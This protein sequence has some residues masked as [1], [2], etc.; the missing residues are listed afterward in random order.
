MKRL[1][2]NCHSNQDTLR[3]C[4]S[5]ESCVEDRGD[6]LQVLRPNWRGRRTDMGAVSARQFK[7]SLAAQNLGRIIERGANG[8]ASSGQDR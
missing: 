1:G 7:H 2:L 5:D 6:V 8:R 3:N 4:N